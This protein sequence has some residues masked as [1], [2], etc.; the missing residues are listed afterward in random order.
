MEKVFLMAGG[1]ALAVL[2]LFF[3]CIFSTLMGGIV[4]WVVGSFF[5]E[6]FLNLRITLGIEH[7]S[8]WEIGCGAGFIGSFFKATVSKS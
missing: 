1:M 5:T 3:V 4:G 8:M 6:T 2:G 7:L